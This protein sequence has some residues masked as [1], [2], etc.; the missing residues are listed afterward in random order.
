[1]THR[2]QTL[3][4]LPFED[5]DRIV[6]DVGDLFYELKNQRLFITG[7]TGT[8]GKWLLESLVYAD[9]KLDLNVD[10]SVLTRNP[11]RFKA[12]G[13]CAAHVHVI[14]G[15]VRSFQLPATAKIN[16][17]IHGATDVVSAAN[18]ADVLQTCALGTAN[19]LS[20]AHSRGAGR[21]LLLSSGAV[22]GK[23]PLELT[24]IPESYIGPI[25]FRSVNA[26]YGEGK[27][28]A[29]LMCALTS[30]SS[31]MVIPVARC[32]AMIG[33]HV[34]L[35]KHFAIGNFI[36]AALRSEP[37]RIEGDGTPVRSYLYMSDVIARLLI[38][39]LD[40]KSDAYNVGGRNPISIM[41]LAL[42]VGSIVNP[43]CPIEIKGKAL[44]G[45][46][47]NRYIPSVSYFDSTWPLPEPVSIEDA[48]RKTADWYR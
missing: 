36:G 31:S 24:E 5:L 15:D 44:H 26:A 30:G 35:D 11:E 16:Y 19:L 18:H 39:L 21:V 37:I 7:G 6:S 1:V 9:K 8:I 48:I 29:E 12:E 23:T 27:R 3:K 13:V 42:K 45:A 25:D 34:P 22:Y 40:G 14:V 46:H 41:D 20:Q 33:P 28:C 4:A 10:I 17:V 32:F 43:Y 2:M 47:A 38:L